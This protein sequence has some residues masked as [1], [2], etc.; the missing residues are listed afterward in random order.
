[1]CI[2]Y[3]I[4]GSLHKAD[5]PHYLRNRKA[6]WDNF[7]SLYNF[8]GLKYPASVSDIKLFEKNNTSVSIT[9]LRYI[10][11]SKKFQCIW[12]SSAGR[13]L[14]SRIA[15]ILLINNHRLP[16][17]NFDRLLS[18]YSNLRNFKFCPRCLQNFYNTERLEKHQK[19][20]FAT[21]GQVVSMPTPARAYHFFD[22]WNKIL[23]PPYILYADIECLLIKP[24]EQDL[25]KTSFNIIQ[26]HV[27]I[28]LGYILISNPSMIATPLAEANQYYVLR[29]RDAVKNFANTLDQ[30]GRKIYDFNKTH[31]YQAKIVTEEDKQRFQNSQQCEYCE[32]KFSNENVIKVWHHCHISVKIIAIIC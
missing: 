13:E 7:L 10:T 14:N 29:G 18:N 24:S 12:H 2:M 4:V 6:K 32:V 26:R 8:E 3:A 20:C 1:M 27:P 5:V 30:L 17:S 9:A 11:S 22:A 19:R 28:A 21:M 31:C 16:I 23:S 25:S 15:Q